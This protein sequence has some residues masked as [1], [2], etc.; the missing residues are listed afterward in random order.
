MIEFMPIPFC[1]KG[2]FDKKLEALFEQ[3]Y[4]MFDDYPDTYAGIYYNGITY[5]NFCK[6]IQE[7]LDKHLEIPDVVK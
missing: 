5:D 7:C 2:R 1:W 6:Y 4:D 3:Y